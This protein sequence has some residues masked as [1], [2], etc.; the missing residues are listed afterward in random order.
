MAE[1]AGAAVDILFAG[2]PD[3]AKF[4]SM[5]A[6][7]TLYTRTVPPSR[8]GELLRRLPPCMLRGMGPFRHDSLQKWVCGFGT[9]APAPHTLL[10]LTSPLH[11]TAMAHMWSRLT[12]I[13]TLTL[14]GLPV[15]Q[16][17]RPR[18]TPRSSPSALT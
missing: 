10:L 1:A 13:S 4:A 16:L 6:V 15:M 8:R 7:E 2:E 17:S 11:T 5:A 18:L 9:A 12:C 3:I 14:L